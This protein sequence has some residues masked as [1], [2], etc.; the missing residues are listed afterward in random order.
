MNRGNPR[1]LDSFV[2]EYD[3]DV[4]AAKRLWGHEDGYIRK[5]AVRLSRPMIVWNS[6]LWVDI[7][8]IL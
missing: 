4:N 3:I 5:A 6:T 7:L 8:K 1:T 2:P